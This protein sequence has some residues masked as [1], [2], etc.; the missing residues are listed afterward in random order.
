[1]VQAHAAQAVASV[2]RS[3]QQQI[4]SIAQQA[5]VDIRPILS[6]IDDA[7]ETFE[8][9]AAAVSQAIE[10]NLRSRVVELRSTGEQTV[11]LVEQQLIARLRNLRPQAQ[12]MLNQAQDA[13]EQRIGALLGNATARIEEGESQLVMR[14]EERRVGK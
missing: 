6:Q 7:R 14:S 8:R 12:V 3:V 11:D 5:R 9:Q 13:I 4:D 10:A 1:Q 2:K